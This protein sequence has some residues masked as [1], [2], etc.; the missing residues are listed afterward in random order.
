MTG[1]KYRQKTTDERL[2][3]ERV[4]TASPQSGE[5]SE[6]A[7][8]KEQ[9]AEQSYIFTHLLKSELMQRLNEFGTNPSHEALYQ[10][11]EGLNQTIQGG[12]KFMICEDASDSHNSIKTVY[13]LEL[14][15]DE[16][17]VYRWR[18]FES[19]FI[20]DSTPQPLRRDVPA[21]KT[22]E[23]VSQNTQSSSDSGACAI[24]PPK[25]GAVKGDLVPGVFKKDSV[26][27]SGE[28][29]EALCPFF[30]KQDAKEI[31]GR[32]YEKILTLLNELKDVQ[33][34]TED[35]THKVMK[36]MDYLGKGWT[37]NIGVYDSKPEI[38]SPVAS[39]GQGKLASLRIPQAEPE[40]H[41]FQFD[42]GRY[43]AIS[44]VETVL[45]YQ[46]Y[47]IPKISMPQ[48]GHI[49]DSG[50]SEARD[51][52][53]LKPEASAGELKPEQKSYL[54]HQSSRQSQ[55]LQPYRAGGQTYMQ[56]PYAHPPAATFSVRGN[57]NPSYLPHYY[58]HDPQSKRSEQSTPLST[59][60]RREP[61][62][63]TV[64]AQ[65]AHISN[66]SKQSN[67]PQ[68]LFN[69]YVK[70]GQSKDCLQLM[71]SAEAEADFVDGYKLFVGSVEQEYRGKFRCQNDKPKGVIKL[72]VLDDVEQWLCWKAYPIKYWSP[73]KRRL[74]VQGNFGS[75]GRYSTANTR[76]ESDRTALAGRHY[77]GSHAP[78]RG[79][80]TPALS[81]RDGTIPMRPG[82]NQ[83]LMNGAMNQAAYPHNYDGI[84]PLHQGLKEPSI[85][86]R[87]ENRWQ[88]QSEYPN[89][90]EGVTLDTH[91][92]G[93]DQRRS[94]Y[95][96]NTRRGD[97]Y[98]MNPVNGFE[99]IRHSP[100]E[101]SHKP[102]AVPTEYQRANAAH[103]HRLSQGEQ[104]FN[105]PERPKLT[106]LL[107]ARPD[108]AQSVAGAKLLTK[109][110]VLDKLSKPMGDAAIFKRNI[111]YLVSDDHDPYNIEA[112]KRL[113][114]LDSEFA[115][116]KLLR[117][118]EGRYLIMGFKF[119]E[120]IKDDT[121]Y[122]I[123]QFL[124]HEKKMA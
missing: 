102:S 15:T 54:S 105:D 67:T 45:T 36:L 16:G 73:E 47:D 13:F 95:P 24:T 71:N 63:A 48:K 122:S 117:A 77:V 3:D 56:Q 5:A 76:P 114:E 44:S 33:L 2:D 69:R 113:S 43:L 17:K 98:R 49:Q 42:N 57:G 99:A 68:E 31:E 65:S 70:M 64:A 92:A 86:R 52:H 74:A 93:G 110:E 8:S 21:T 100:S 81:G 87:P 40:L 26:Y 37:W 6:Q 35:Y 119:K 11:K 23:S 96:Y 121:F 55:P 12:A 53:T 22:L 66:G 103:S 107:N 101:V 18:C 58:Q 39:S 61:Q 38:V 89:G 97:D 112:F 124:D 90:N 30:V 115:S 4:G 7:C 34:K 91:Y 123:L 78:D 79:T 82:Q 84:R 62:A 60:M 27:R 83:A 29:S 108:L 85:R 106:Q 109:A 19:E 14:K 111:N 1:Y 25:A 80:H 10:L 46:G 28:V 72:L 32:N 116:Y 94:P 75:R 120:P 51:Y 104:R 118:G 9:L 20:L 88:N 50:Q 41:L 59:D